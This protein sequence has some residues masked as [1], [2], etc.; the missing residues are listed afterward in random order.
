MKNGPDTAEQLAGNAD[1]QPF[2]RSARLSA[3][4]DILR[5]AP[6]F[7]T[8]AEKERAQR[9]VRREDRDRFA[10]GRVLTRTMIAEMTGSP[11]EV[12]DFSTGPYGKP[13]L[14]DRP[15]LC[16]SIA[17]SG[18]VV[19]VGMGIGM[20]LGVDVEMHRRD[21]ELLSLARVIFTKEEQAG[22]FG[23]P[24]IDPVPAFFRQWSA[25]EAVV[26]ALGT[27]LSLDPLR[28]AL[29][30]TATAPVPVFHGPGPDD[31]GAGW[32]IVDIPTIDGHSAV[33]AWRMNRRA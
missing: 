17:H 19:L 16:F 18:D 6:A 28:F 27:G 31:V 1:A 4:A 12:A 8:A 13:F 29:D 25:K 5:A 21:I 14:P 15:D 9:F 32:T 26:K 7:L 22:I 33:A 30:L 23:R 3:S 10:L 2:F 11:A 24:E 20:D